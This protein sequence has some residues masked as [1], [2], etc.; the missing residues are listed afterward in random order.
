MSP[1]VAVDGGGRDVLDFI[2][3]ADGV[4]MDPGLIASRWLGRVVHPWQLNLEFESPIDPEASVLVLDGWVE[5]PYSQTMFAAWQAG[6]SY[7]PITIEAKGDEG[8]WEVVHADI[9]YP[10]GMTRTSGYPLRG[11]PAGTR[12][13][14]LTTDLEI[15]LD[16]ARV[17][18]VEACPEAVIRHAP[19]EAARLEAVGYPQ[20]ASE[21]HERADFDWSMRSPFWDTRVQAGEYTAFGDVLPAV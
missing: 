18:V 19:L 3:Q 17:V 11:L 9:G 21:P 1:V 6:V 15:Y 4:P 13:V 2:Q 20:R 5:Y 16:A 14:R 12:V 8:T 7:R 10:A